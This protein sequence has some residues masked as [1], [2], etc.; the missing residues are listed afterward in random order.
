MAEGERETVAEIWGEDLGGAGGGGE[1]EEGDGG[2]D[3]G[4]KKR[5]MVCCFGFPMATK[6]ERA[7]AAEER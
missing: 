3:L 2:S 4:A 7:N 5:E 6:E 1:E